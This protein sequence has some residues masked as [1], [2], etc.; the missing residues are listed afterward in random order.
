MEKPKPKGS[1]VCPKCGQGKFYYS[2]MCATCKKSPIE[3][4][5]AII[6]ACRGTV[7]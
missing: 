1:L 2:P 7:S 6:R 4:L 5:N 3:L